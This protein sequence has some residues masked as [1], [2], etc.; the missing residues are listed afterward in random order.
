MED[1]STGNGHSI[2]IA[3]ATDTYTL[4]HTYCQTS[5]LRELASPELVST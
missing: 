5:C 1:L 2:R 4:R 3:H